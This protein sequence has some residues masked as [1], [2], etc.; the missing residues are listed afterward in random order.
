MKVKLIKKIIDEVYPK[1]KRQLIFDKHTPG[2][3][4]VVGSRRKDNTCSKNYFYS[5]RPKGSKHSTRIH[6][7][8]ADKLSVA[9]ARIRI[10]KVQSDIFNKK[11]PILIKQ[12]LKNEPTLGE[13]VE[14]YFKTYLNKNNFKEK[15][16]ENIRSS[17]RV[18]ILHQP[19][20]PGYHQ[21]F[22][23][24]VK[25][26]KISEIKSEDIK[27]I[28]D[29]VKV[30]SGYAANRLVEYLRS[31]FTW[32]I[33]KKYLIM[34]PVKFSGDDKFKEYQTNKILTEDQRENLLRRC[35]VKDERTNKLNV[36]YYTRNDLNLVSCLAI[37][38]ALLTGRRQKSEGFCITFGQ[39][40]L[41]QN[42]IYFD[43]TKTGAAEYDLGPRA[44][45]LIKTIQRSKFLNLN[46]PE[47]RYGS[48][49]IPATIVPGPWVENPGDFVF[50]SKT[51]KS[52]HVTEA[53]KTWRRLLKD[54]RINYL[55]LK[56]CRHTFGT[57]LLSK[58]RS[59]TAV[60]A[61][62]GHTNAATTQRYAKILAK[63]VKAALT[64]M[65]QTQKETA[66]I[67]K[68]DK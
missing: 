14:V 25:D 49:I 62:L 47:K 9:A 48:K 66:Q 33:K 10:K 57:L 43:D 15:S 4:L 21:Y 54:C 38:W 40:D 63:D 55:P 7:G 32:A 31:M 64:A 19:K 3:V 22:T 60:Q 52:G 24:S 29:A 30:K 13:L 27:Q 6:I 42:K 18:W 46:Y 45:D 39:L 37:A 1:D 50:P 11:D 41:N 2:L 65:D 34:N 51:S 68:L 67:L 17:F 26:K 58:G 53:R 23:Y 35:F 8:S 16:I 28:H 56:Q 36:D 61:A 20:K 59:L 5:Y 44:V 12:K